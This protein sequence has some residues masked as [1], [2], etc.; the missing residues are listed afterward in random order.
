MKF[1]QINFIKDISKT[2][3]TKLIYKIYNFKIQ[4]FDSEVISSLNPYKYRKQ[5]IT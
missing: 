4:L 1:K 3:Y 5:L 2:K